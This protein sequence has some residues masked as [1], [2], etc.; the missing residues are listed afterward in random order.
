V[1][2]YKI[3]EKQTFQYFNLVSYRNTI[4]SSCL[5]HKLNEFILSLNNYN[6][7][8]NGPLIT[9]THSVSRN[10][11]IE[12]V[13]FEIMVPVK[14][15]IK[16]NP[17]FIYKQEFKL[18][19][20]IRLMYEGKMNGINSAYEFLVKYISQNNL[21]QITSA[22]NINLSEGTSENIIIDICIGIN[23]SLL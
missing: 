9:S 14:G 17:P 10:N 20:A 16:K 12:M 6:L 21:H 1:E 23:P 5:H 19:N 3:N 7:Q 15:E 2:L 11:G 4:P 8:K 22:Y 18:I 13:D